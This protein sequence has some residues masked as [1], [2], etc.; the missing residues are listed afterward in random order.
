M[1]RLFNVRRRLAKR[2]D[3]F[4]AEVQKL[5][6]RALLAGVVTVAISKAGD[7][8]I[9]GDSKDNVVTVNIDDGEINIDPSD[10]TRIKVGKT[11]FAPGENVELAKSTAITG[12]LTVKLGGG[13]DEFVVEVDQNSTVGTEAKPKNVNIDGG[14]GDDEIVISV[15]DADLTIFGKL[16]VTSGSGD[17]TVAISAED[18]GEIAVGGNTSV[19]SGT[20]IDLIVISD[21]DVIEDLLGTGLDDESAD[22][23]KDIN[24][25]G[26]LN[27]NASTGNDEV[28][29]IGVAVEKGATLD[30]GLGD[31]VLAVVDVNVGGDLKLTFG[32]LN[33]LLN[34]SVGGKITG[35]SGSGNDRFGVDNLN[36]N[37]NIDLNLSSGNDQL[38]LGDVDLSDNVK[39]VK[40]NGGSG[41]DSISGN[42]ALLTDAKPKNFENDD[43][44]LGAILD[45]ALLTLFGPT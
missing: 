28:A 5:E 14:T 8:T 45:A 22:A 20:G 36:A 31:D 13:N 42:P 39:S 23:E 16:T 9:T 24:F 35:N 6:T 1:R 18:G 26:T 21:G 3:N 4:P 41:T 40:L 29:V 43:A 33:A 38:A 12:N 10:D 7:V 15:D 25:G 27:V 17:D 34:V 11:T 32:D 44:N 30:T 2:F 37:G 19:N